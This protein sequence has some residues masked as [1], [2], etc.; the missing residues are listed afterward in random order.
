MG[1]YVEPAWSADDQVGRALRSYDDW[2]ETYFNR[3]H[4]RNSDAAMAALKK[5]FA[6]DSL[7][8]LLG[9]EA[10][11]QAT[12]FVFLG[13]QESSLQKALT[14]A[15]AGDIVIDLDIESNARVYSN[16]LPLLLFGGKVWRDSLTRE[17]QQQSRKSPST[18]CLS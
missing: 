14:C 9:L 17:V 12:N 2:V 16:Q 13:K 11:A 4:A 8:V 3:A 18:S 10:W 5:A 1:A 7:D 6:G 15:G